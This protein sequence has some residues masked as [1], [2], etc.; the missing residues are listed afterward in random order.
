[1]AAGTLLSLGF[2]PVADREHTS[3]SLFNGLTCLRVAP[4]TVLSLNPCLIVVVFLLL[5]SL[6]CS[7]T[8]Y[9]QL[10]TIRLTHTP[11]KHTR[12]HMRQGK[13]KDSRSPVGTNSEPQSGRLR[14]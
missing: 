3:H 8:V 10:P 11:G 12:T 2:P 13:H 14:V 9:L 6:T 4:P 1:M 5:I 7:R